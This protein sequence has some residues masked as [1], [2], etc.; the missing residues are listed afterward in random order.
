VKREPTDFA[1]GDCVQY[2]VAKRDLTSFTVPAVVVGHTRRRVVVEF[3]H[4][5]DGRI[6]QRAARP[7]KLGKAAA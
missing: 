4:W 6:V 1:V 7:I 5:D 2:E 3:A